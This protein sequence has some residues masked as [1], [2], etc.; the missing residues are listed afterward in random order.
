MSSKRLPPCSPRRR[1]LIGAGVACA[2]LGPLSSR[3]AA[4]PSRPVT[5]VVPYAPGGPADGLV[6]AIAEDLRRRLGQPFVPDFRSGAAGIIGAGAVAKASADGY[7]LLFS[8]SDTLVN[9]VALYRRLPYEPQRDFALI[10]QIGSLPLVLATHGGLPVS[11][12]A[13][14]AGAARALGGKISYGSGGSGTLFHLAGEVLLNR[15]LG[16]DATHVPYRGIGP[17]TVDLVGRQITAA[18]GLEPAYRGFAA[19]G[20]LRM[21][22]MTGDARVAELPHLRTFS[23]LGY[24][25]PVLRMRPWAAL[26]GPAGT[27]SDIVTLLNTAV[28]GALDAPE[29]RAMLDASGFQRIAN[30]PQ[31]AHA[32]LEHDLANVVPLIRELGIEAQ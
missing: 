3:A 1:Q 8:T 28:I 9:N 25:E 14:F 29:V 32:A 21:L 12:P 30:S 19:D 27:P 18:F 6:R 10:T 17:M 4:Y 11:N 13:E 7:T 16:L 26:L 15:R 2:A 31:A 20:R 5:I 23:E 22:G 24:V